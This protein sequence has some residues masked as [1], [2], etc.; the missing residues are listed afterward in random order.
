MLI[1]A[2]VERSAG[3]WARVALRGAV[4]SEVTCS[5]LRAAISALLAGR[6]KGLGI[7][8]GGVERVGGGG[9]QVLRAAV[10]AAADAGTWIELVNAPIGVHRALDADPV[11]APVLA[12][13]AWRR[14]RAPSWLVRP[15]QPTMTRV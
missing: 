12:A 4:D 14:E 7:D 6:P 13:Y 5:I 9:L 1:V 2:T 10:L 15:E 3:S 8:L 11:L